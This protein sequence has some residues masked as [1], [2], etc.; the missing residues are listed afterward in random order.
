LSLT[1]KV[2]KNTLYNFLSQFAAFIAP[3]LLTP[4]IIGKI[5]EENFGIYAIILGFTGTFGL[6]DFSLSTSFVKFISEHYNKKNFSK[7]NSVLNTG[8]LFYLIF[9]VLIVIA[10]Y[11]FSESFL[12]IINIPDELFRTGVSAFRISLITFFISNTFLI[13]TS[14]LISIQRMYIVSITAFTATVFNIFFTV[15]FLLMNYGLIGLMWSQFITV[16]IISI[17]PVYYSFKHIPELHIGLGHPFKNAI[18]DMGKF[19]IQMQLSKLAT[20]ASEKYDEILL[21]IFTSLSNVTY[22]NLAVKLGRFGRFIPMQVVNQVAPVAAEFNAKEETEK[23]KRLFGD[24]SKYL[25]LISLPII[26][27]IF[28]F[29]DLL[30]LTWMGEEYP[31]TVHIIRVLMVGQAVNLVFSAPGNSIT[32]NIGIPKYQMFEGLINLSLNLVLSLILIYKFGVLGAAYGNT[33]AVIISSSYVFF[34]S[35]SYFSTAKN[36]LLRSVYLRPLISCITSSVIA[37]FINYYL[38]KE[39]IVYAGRWTG[40]LLIII[41]AAVFL[42]VYLLMIVIFRYMNENDKLLMI[43]TLSKFIPAGIINKFRPNR[44]FEYKGELISFFIVTHNRLN[45]LKKCV[46]SFLKTTGNF[47]FELIIWDNNSNDGTREYLSGL[48]KSDQRIKLVLHNKNAGTNA[49]G[50][51]AEICSGEYIFGIDDDCLEFP[52][53]WIM[54]MLS[55]YN[56]IPFMGYLATDVIQNEFTNG[57]KESIEKY[58][59]ETYCD[60]NYNLLIGPTGGWCFLISRK[61]YNEVGKLLILNDRIFFAEDGDYTV[62]TLARGLK[63]GI[64]KEVKILHATGDYYNKEYAEILT[65]KY[66]SYKMPLPFVYKAQRKLKAVLSLGKRLFRKIISN[67]LTGY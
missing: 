4:F 37:Y 39:F 36:S 9:S 23:L 10:G 54:K 60:K 25:T 14:V 3:L 11:F 48:K 47:N 19:G 27:F 43:K 55:A 52:E 8:M 59:I 56:C 45:M 21:G 63:V 62:R 18:K 38:L 57:A 67:I 40:F 33:I 12:R 20:F 34:V 50:F 51:S 35:S 5:G 15:L 16:C 61:V 49:K 29:A 44:I 6:L 22:F 13:F 41:N 1:D 7:L 24:I 66:K 65:N 17:T 26:L 31:L 2:I 46:E 64:L 42:F 30:L 58:K 28:T 53:D 32:P